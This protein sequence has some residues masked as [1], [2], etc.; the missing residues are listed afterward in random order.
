M[1]EEA[2]FY[3]RE[4]ELSHVLIEGQMKQ[5]RNLKIALDLEKKSVKNMIASFYWIVGSM[6]VVSIC[7]IAHMYIYHKNDPC[8]FSPS[9]YI[10]GER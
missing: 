10:D 7:I 1:N 8:L 2:N 9:C 6:I 3:K 5:I 4:L